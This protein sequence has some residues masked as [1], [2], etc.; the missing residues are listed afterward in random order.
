V[1]EGLQP[2]VPEY[3]QPQH[4]R[5]PCSRQELDTSKNLKRYNKGR[6]KKSYRFPSDD[7][8]Y[9]AKRYPYYNVRGKAGIKA[10]RKGR[11]MTAS[12]KRH[13]SIAMRESWKA[14]REHQ[15]GVAPVE[16]PSNN[17]GQAAEAII[18]TAQVLRSVSL[19]LKL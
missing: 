15:N 3:A 6:K 14:K 7:P 19:G 13:L 2:L 9:R 18:L 1:Q 4:A 17:L 12:E 8:E 16:Q 11:K 5:N 10:R